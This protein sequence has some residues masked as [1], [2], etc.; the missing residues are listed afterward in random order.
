MSENF[1]GKVS[2]L[3][4]GGQ[5][6]VHNNG[7]VVFVPYAA[8]G[9]LISYQ[10]IQKKKNF[11]FGKI[12]AVLEEGTS[13]VHPEC[14]YF[15]SCGGCQLQHI[16]A[17]SQ[18]EQKRQWIVDALQRIGGIDIAV[19]P[20]LA[21]ERQWAYRR[22]IS[23]T[24]K[25][26]SVGYI[27]DDNSTLIAV[28]K[29]PIFVPADNS[30]IG[31][32]REIVS[33]WDVPLENEGKVTVLKRHKN[34]FLLHFHLKEMV[35]NARES[36]EKALIQ[37]PCFLGIV[38]S[39]PGKV[40]TLGYVSTTE[41]I[42]GLSITYGLDVFIQ[43]HSEQSSNIYRSICEYVKTVRPSKVL[44][45]YCGIGISSLMISKYSGS[46]T[47][48][49]M[50]KEAVKC[51]QSNAEANA[52]SNV[53]FKSAKV[54]AALSELLNAER[55]DLIIVNPPREGLLPK[56]VDTLKKYP[57][58][59]LIYISCMP[60]TLARDAKKLVGTYRLDSVQAYDMFPQTTHVETLAAFRT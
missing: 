51:A 49:E 47:G 7:L 35:Q 28:E 8:P 33:K 15:G 18:L 34:G 57:A 50:N 30:V 46:V 37:Y 48:I 12:V 55:P 44:D 1:T 13:R 39:A 10:I 54:E 19:P 5:G 42:E 36:M 45:L 4:F 3:A 52:I 32:V 56:V 2:S 43:N 17:P 25:G 27:A 23:L 24:I 9:D 26:K 38:V 58:K 20:V 21:A 16:N 59:H 31:C 40:L 14:P 11:A 53:K 6:I 29:C 22:R 60:S 41:Q